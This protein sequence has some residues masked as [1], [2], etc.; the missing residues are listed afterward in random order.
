MPITPLHLGMGLAAK[1]AAP[2]YF[3]LAAFTL[4]NCIIDVEPILKVLTNSTEPLH[5]LTHTVPVGA[6][7]AALAAIAVKSLRP[8]Q[9]TWLAAAAGAAYG[10]ATH[11]GLDALYHADVAASLGLP[12]AAGVVSQ[13]VID[14]FLALNIAAFGPTFY[15]RA[16]AW[17]LAQLASAAGQ[18]PRNEA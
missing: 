17:V 8:D 18:Q 6:A 1:Y 10:I 2:R 7:I 11:L 5:S 4:A 3:S 13:G 14:A 9:T 16:R 15:R 12:D